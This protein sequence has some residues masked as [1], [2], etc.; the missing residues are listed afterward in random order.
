M[1]KRIIPFLLSLLVLVNLPVTLLHASTTVMTPFEKAIVA[2][3]GKDTFRKMAQQDLAIRAYQQFCDYHRDRDGNVKFSDDFAGEFVEGN[4]LHVFLTDTSAETV[5][6]YSAFFKGYEDIVVFEKKDYSFNYLHAL[7]NDLIEQADSNFI[8]YS[9]D[10]RT[11]RVVVTVDESRSVTADSL[12]TASTKSGLPIIYISGTPSTPDT[13]ALRGGDAMEGITLSVCGIY[14]NLPAIVTCGHRG[15][16][17]VPIGHIY[18]M[19]NAPDLAMSTVVFS[20]FGPQGDFSI[21]TVN[22]F[23]YHT[24]CETITEAEDDDGFTTTDYVS[25]SGG[26]A[27]LPNGAVVV[28]YGSVA[29]F[30]TLKILDMWSSYYYPG[31][32]T[33][34]ANNNLVSVGPVTVSNLAETEV[35][36]GGISRSGDSGGPVIRYDSSTDTWWY[37]GCYVVAN[38]A[39]DSQT[40]GIVE[41]T[42]MWFTPY[43]QMGGFTVNN[44][45]WE[46]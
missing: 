30:A 35:Q 44:M 3:V 28:K 45:T 29:G 39:T 25:L 37:V 10:S 6:R 12:N 46:G 24:T 34:D 13:T 40:G 22:D 1:R 41:A 42:K 14:N 9:V 16:G 18:S 2:S 33:Y 36:P 32:Y 11:N 7:K 27:N 21:A 31:G 20:S 23:W 8:S 26:I 4:K 19:A 38:R 17:A 15:V 43:R 5:K